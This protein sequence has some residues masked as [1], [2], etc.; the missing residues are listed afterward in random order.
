MALSKITYLEILDSMLNN[1]QNAQH[2]TIVNHK[3]LRPALQLLV[4]YKLLVTLHI[5]ATFEEY[6]C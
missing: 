4:N 5:C 6:C 3:H 2:T 1:Q